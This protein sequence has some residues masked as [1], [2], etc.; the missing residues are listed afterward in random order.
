MK[1]AGIAFAIV[2]YALFYAG[3]SN[4]FSG[5]KGWGFLQSLLN[6]GELN[7]SL[8]DLFSSGSSS[9]STSG[10][11]SSSGDDPCRLLVGSAKTF[12]EQDNAKNDPCA[13]VSGPAKAYCQK[14]NA[15]YYTARGIVL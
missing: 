6:K 14:T 8:G 1:A 9:D 2:G 4:L 11:S 5:G 15:A 3:A 10:G 13:S 12:C 7:S